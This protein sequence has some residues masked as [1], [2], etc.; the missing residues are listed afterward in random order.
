MMHLKC[1]SGFLLRSTEN[2]LVWNSHLSVSCSARMLGLWVYTT[3]LGRISFLMDPI[4]VSGLKQ[5]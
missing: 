2:R 1:A 5:K 3:T 4:V